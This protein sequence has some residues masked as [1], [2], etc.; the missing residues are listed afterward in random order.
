MTIGIV[1]QPEF[2]EWRGSD[3]EDR[4][5]A[6]GIAHGSP[7]LRDTPTYRAGY[8]P[9]ACNT[10][11]LLA[12]LIRG[13]QN[14]EAASGLLDSFPDLRSISNA[15]IQELT[16][17]P[18]IGFTKAAAIKAALELGRRMHLPLIATATIRSPEDA[19]EIL[20]PMMGHLE[21][22]CLFV[23]ALNTRNRLIGEPIQVYLG[24]LNASIVRTGEVFRPAVRANAA[25]IIAA[26]NH[27]SGAPRSA[28]V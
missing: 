15:T 10:H 8:T 16:C 5:E 20:M 13:S 23:L 19:A 21:K 3:S 6:R 25:A 14:L 11:E 24:S 7:A 22:E 9:G 1:K 12:A 28:F 18:G 2:P 4:F 26:H 27:P 17:I